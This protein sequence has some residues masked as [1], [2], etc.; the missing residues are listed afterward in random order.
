M[1]CVLMCVDSASDSPLSLQTNAGKCFKYKCC[2]QLSH[3]YSARDCPWPRDLSECF[4]RKMNSVS[5]SWFKSGVITLTWNRAAIS[6][7]YNHLMQ[8]RSRRWPLSLAGSDRR[9]LCSR[10]CSITPY[11]VALTSHIL[12][13]IISL[14]SCSLSERTRPLDSGALGFI[15]Y[16]TVSFVWLD[17]QH[18]YYYRISISISSC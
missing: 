17:I 2:E 10:L 8:D 13:Y 12:N 4:L 15:Y 1:P 9:I 6:K 18:N 11:T 3:W 14:F 16:H 5:R 7:S